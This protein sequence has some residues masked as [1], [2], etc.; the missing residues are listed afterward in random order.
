M[1]FF[2]LLKESKE[3]SNMDEEH[4][5]QIL[6]DNDINSIVDENVVLVDKS[7]VNEAKKILKK[8]GYGFLKVKAN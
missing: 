4:V 2:D 5:V 6:A 7:D 8:A 3:L 1:N